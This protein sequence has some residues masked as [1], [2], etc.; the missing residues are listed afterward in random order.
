ML[1]TVG[2]VCG[3]TIAYMVVSVV[4]FEC[5]QYRDY[6]SIHYCC[7]C[8]ETKTVESE[9]DV[10]P[11]TVHIMVRNP[12]GTVQLGTVSKVNNVITD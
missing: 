8:C 3:G 11:P 12:D 4:V 5:V 2:Q 1:C 9:D 7:K 6:F 10:Q